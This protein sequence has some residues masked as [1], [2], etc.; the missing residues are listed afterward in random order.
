MTLTSTKTAYW[1]GFQDSVP[2]IIVVAP[3]AMV[4]GVVATEA[5]LNLAQVMGFSVLV[6]AGAAQ[7]TA[8]QLMA[9]N[10]PTIVVLTSA[11]AVN[12]RMAMYSASLA[13]HLGKA[14][15]WQ[16]GLISYLLVDQSYAVSILRYEA[17]P[18]MTVKSKIA[19][20]FGV[21]TPVV[22]VWYGGTF[23]GAV[24]GAA[25]PPE[26]GL[27][28]AVPIAFIAIIAPAL[29][30][31]PHI[32]AAFISVIAVLALGW[33]PYNLGLMIAGAMGM[34]T[35]AQVELMLERRS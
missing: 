3:F 14:S 10:A 27:D 16:R 20:Y 1:R 12:L 21:V 13:S 25:I 32:A 4:F 11:L 2:F 8:M 15:L 26:Y 18:E 22:P 30:S 5:G 9:E 29:R 17:E 35:G 28:F 23:F 31:L 7:L 24:L 33:V 19:F 34:A 6:I